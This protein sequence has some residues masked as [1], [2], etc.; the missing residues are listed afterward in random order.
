MD[1]KILGVF[2]DPDNN[3]Q[4]WI[5]NGMEYFIQDTFSPD[6]EIIAC[7]G[8]SISGSSYNEKKENARNIVIEFNSIVCE[9][10]IDLSYSEWGT[11]AG[12]F[13]GYAKK[14]GLTKEFKENCII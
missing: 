1:K 13:E 4:A 12:I 3:L 7:L 5:Y 2:K 6:C 8:F 9:N 14:Y 10:S 11:I